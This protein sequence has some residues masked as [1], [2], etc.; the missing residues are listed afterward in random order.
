[1][2][3]LDIACNL[4][5]EFEGF[6]PSPYICPAGI[7]TIGYGCTR[8]SD[9]ARITMQDCSIDETQAETMLRDAMSKALQSA[10]V[11]CPNLAEQTQERQAAIADFVYNLGAARLMSSTLKA[12]ILADEWDEV[13]AQL[14][15]WVYAGAVIL[16]GLKK[17]RAA[18]AALI[19]QTAA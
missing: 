6:R 16:D 5:K 9:G 1:M 17:R 2:N 3:A 13:P 8:Y 15:R 11:I 7:P 19:T 14:M 12:K 4:A 18:E 10:L